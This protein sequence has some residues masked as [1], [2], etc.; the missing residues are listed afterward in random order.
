MHYLATLRLFFSG[1]VIN[2]YRLR[3]TR[4]EF[5]TNGGK[6]RA[7]TDSDLELHFCFNT[8]VARWLR[9]H[10]IEANPYIFPPPMNRE[11]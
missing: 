2:D 1:G 6:W 9:S 8:E 11:V 10:S 3:G 5:R 7:L 4:V